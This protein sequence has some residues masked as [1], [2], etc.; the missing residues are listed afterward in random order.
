MRLNT[1][2]GRTMYYTKRT[3]DG[4]KRVGWLRSKALRAARG[5][6]RGMAAAR[7]L[8]MAL[9]PTTLAFALALVVTAL[10]AGYA[11]AQGNS[12]ANTAAQVPALLGGKV[13]ALVANTAGDT[14]ASAIDGAGVYVGSVTP[15]G[16]NWVLQAFP[17]G[18]MA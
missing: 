7:A 1:A 17:S 2:K 16:I 12:P 15:A 13:S 10:P 8:P 11:S 6:A 18:V 9:R 3:N 5:L 14:L 4:S